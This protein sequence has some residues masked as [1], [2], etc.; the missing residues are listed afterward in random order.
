MLSRR[1][2]L[3]TSACLPAVWWTGCGGSSDNFGSVDLVWGGKG[4]GPGRF[5]KPRAI[6]ID[7]E[8]RLFVVD[9][10]A[11]IQV[12]DPDGKH[13]RGWQTPNFK[14]GRPTG[15]TVAP[16]GALLVADTHY[17][18]VLVY[19]PEGE[20]LPDRT[21]GGTPGN[22]PGEFGL[23]TSVAVDAEGCMY[24][25][26]YGQF[27]RI[28][29]FSPRGEFLKQWG[30]HGEAPGQFVRPQSMVFD[31]LQRLWVCDACNH[32]VQVFDREG[33]LLLVWGLEGTAPGSL[34][35]P[36]DLAFDGSGGLF[37]CEYGG[38]RV[39]RF[40]LG[41]QPLGCWG[42]LGAEPGQVRDPWGLVIDSR[43]RLHVL[44]TGNN[45]VQRLLV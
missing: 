26:E 23:V 21:L 45:R 3:K 9:F 18:Q 7:A 44:D 34:Y 5:Q 15:L 43:G 30:S 24:V 42:R 39:Q 25:S 4:L 10:T 11:R 6:A 20:L 38:Q 16:D 8:D 37:L 13:L 19:S 12:F 22:G 35:Y 2:L 27:D 40:T 29:K 1:C 14:K 36:Y 41:G 17:H 33:N 32:R 28:Q 31:K